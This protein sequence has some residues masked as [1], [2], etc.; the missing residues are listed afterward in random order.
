M[1]LLI[2]TQKMDENDD[3]LGFMHGWVNEFSKRCEKITVICLEKGSL[4]LPA[5]VSVYSLGKEKKKAGKLTYA[6]RFLS[7]A[8]RLRKEYTHVFVHM[9]YEYVILGGFLWRILGKKIS[10]WYAH[11]HVPW[12]LYPALWLSHV[13]FTSTKSGFRITSP[14]V[15]VIGQGIDTAKFKSHKVPKVESQNHKLKIISVGRISPSKDYETLIKAAEI[16]EKEGL[17]FEITLIGKPAT[18]SDLIYQEKIKKM[19]REKQLETKIRFVGGV[20]NRDLPVHLEKA[21]LFV[22]AGLTGS[23][24]KAMVEAMSME[25]P[26]ITSNGAMR[27]VLG[28]YKEEF[29]Y[30]KR[31][32]VTLASKILW[33]A[34]MPFVERENLGKNMR[35]IVER[36]HALDRF[37]SEITDGLRVL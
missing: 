11:G 14:K 20:A 6:I 24:D 19:V 27:E 32:S 25:L 34:N 7:L 28:D 37:I 12:L 15:R 35:K 23:L 21:D 10:L 30:A 31:D 4:S 18:S 2:V 26:V 29:M 17:N 22:N 9:N 5:N 16:L 1:K 36:D 33:F 13:V 8:F 3:V